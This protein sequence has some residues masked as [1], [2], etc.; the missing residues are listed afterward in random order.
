MPNLKEWQRIMITHGPRE[1]GCFKAVYPNETL[2]EVQCIKGKI[3]VVA[4]GNG[5]DYVGHPPGVNTR[6]D[7]SDNLFVSMTGYSS[8]QDSQA[9]SD[10]YGIQV[11]SESNF[12]TSV[13]GLPT[14]GWQQFIFDNYFTALGI[15][16]GLIGMQYWAIGYHEVYGNCPSGWTQSGNN[17]WIDGPETSTYYEDPS[18]L[19]N[20]Q[21]V[22][23]A[24]CS[25]CGTGGYDQIVLTDSNGNVWYQSN[26]DE[27]LYLYQHWNYSEANV[28][29][30]CCTSQANFNPGVSITMQNELWS[31]T[32]RGA[33]DPVCQN[34]G[35]T[36]ET[37]NLYL[38]SCS[39]GYDSNTGDYYYRYA[40]FD[41]YLLTMNCC[42]GLTCSPF[43]EAQWAYQQVQISAQASCPPGKRGYLFTGWTGTGSGSYSGGND[44]ATITMN[45]AI[46][47]TAK[48]L[49]DPYCPSNPTG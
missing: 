35:Y 24:N 39:A 31:S 16:Y 3:Q 33:I 23:T 2:E 19:A 12:P 38:G 14:G 47:E 8:E 28:F 44:P 46:T 40:Q 48:S 42:T 20:T 13:N 6:I 30:F 29:G 7:E 21:I 11:N 37:N 36:G 49:Y 41:S 17:C 45:G 10:Y 1:A 25:P 27:A 18:N 32:N 9:G 5:N 4:V 22:A 26:T 15:K 34:T 43:S